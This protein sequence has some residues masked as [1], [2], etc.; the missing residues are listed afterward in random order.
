MVQPTGHT[1]THSATARLHLWWLP[2]R[3]HPSASLCKPLPCFQTFHTHTRNH[4]ASPLCRIAVRG[5]P[6]LKALHCTAPDT[7]HTYIAHTA[8]STCKHAACTTTSCRRQPNTGMSIKASMHEARPLLLLGRSTTNQVLQY[9]RP[10]RAKL[11]SPACCT[12][13]GACRPCTPTTQCTLYAGVH[14][15]LVDTNP[16]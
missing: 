11:G 7:T 12:G 5:L 15:H 10:A 2:Q 8:H 3:P 6:G 4:L 13:P 16:R 9:P 1:E 14:T